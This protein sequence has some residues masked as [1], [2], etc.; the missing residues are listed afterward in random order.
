MLWVDWVILAI[1]AISASISL[2]RGFVREAMSLAGWVIAFFIAKGFYQDLALFLADSIE[3]PSLRFG[4]AW[5]MLFFATLTV[6]GLVNYLIGRLIQAVGL[7][8]MDRL[9]GMVFGALR[10]ILVV[11]LVAIGLKAFTPVPQDPWWKKS[12]L[13]P[14]VEIL[15]NWFYDHMRSVIPGSSDTR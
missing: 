6:A 8:G 4:V 9:M 10:G 2:I 14:H 7:S 15:G 1:I 13:I 3:T 5:V 12:Q 11:S